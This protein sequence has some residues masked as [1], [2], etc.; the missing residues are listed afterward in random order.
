MLGWSA[1][2]LRSPFGRTPLGD[3]QQFLYLN[4]IGGSKDANG[5]LP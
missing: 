3:H 1:P 4:P 2:R 5:V